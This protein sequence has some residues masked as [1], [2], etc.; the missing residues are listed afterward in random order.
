MSSHHNGIKLEVNNRKIFGISPNILK[1]DNTLLNNPW[2]NK[3]TN[4]KLECI[5]NGMKMKPTY[6]NLWDSTKSVLERSQ[7]NNLSFHLKELEKKKIK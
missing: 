7:V 2:S 5:L 4:G 1:L 3:N 6:Q